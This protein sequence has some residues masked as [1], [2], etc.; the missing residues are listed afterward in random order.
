MNSTTKLIC[1]ALGAFAIGTESYVVAGVLPTIASDLGV[2]VPLAGQLITA[3]AL[4]YAFGSPLIA[5]AT[6]G[7]ERRRLLLV[8]I[9]MF[10]LLNLFAAFS[11]TYAQLFAVRIG[12]GLAA[13]TFMPAASA[14]AVAA[15]PA[16]HRGRAL[17]IIFGGLTVAMV[18]GAPIGVLL[19]G[20]FGWRVIFLVVAAL[21]FVALAGLAF[22][23]KRIQADA[24]VGLAE[25]LAIAR[26]PDVLGTLA[27]TVITITGVYTI[28]SYL[29]S[30]LQ[31]TAH[32]AGDTLALVLFL[33]G[34]GSTAGNILAGGAT[35]RI[36]PQRV[37]TRV[38]LGLV[39]LFALLSL[40]G[41]LF[42]PD[43]ARWIIVPL[44]A[45]W[46]FVGFSFPSAQQA[47]M[48]T[49]APKLAPITLSLNASA[50]YFGASLGALLGSFV[51]AHG[52][53]GALGWMGALCEVNAF[54]LL[55]FIRRRRPAAEPR[56]GS[57]A[58][59]LA[60]AA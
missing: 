47:H 35:D 17:S 1:L 12:L 26:R 55:K 4:T 45:L 57:V 59:P 23:L 7:V 13:G 53:V 14:Y 3:F 54:L 32:I 28:Y 41:L 21:A 9:A 60:E 20:H 33:F 42:P 6:G 18:I 25:R 46:G 49:L 24:A 37:I 52:S 30:F 16:E 27:V 43:A 31:Q 51:V 5:V 44:I 40:T 39:G 38:L 22:T 48:V 10:G 15:T 58:E 36:G 8:S 50:I 11:H 2:T 29:A 34:L 19:G 56:P